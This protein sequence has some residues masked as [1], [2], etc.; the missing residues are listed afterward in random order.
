MDDYSPP[1]VTDSNGLISNIRS[2][3]E[4]KS[5]EELKTR[6]SVIRN[7]ALSVS[8][9]SKGY[10]NV[11]GSEDI[12]LNI[13]TLLKELDQ[14]C[15]SFTL[16]RGIYYA[17]RLIKSLDRRKTTSFSDINL[18][19][20]KDYDSILTDSF[21]NFRRRDNQGSHR[22]WY[23]G[24][25][26]PQ[27]PNQLLQRFTKRGE[28]VLDPFTGS[29]TTLIE[30]KRLGRNGIGIELNPEIAGKSELVVSTEEN[31]FNVR[32]KLL[33]GDSSTISRKE[34]FGDLPV[35]SAQFMILHPPY[36]DIIKFSNDSRD[37][38]NSLTTEDFLR[39]FANVVR[40]VKGFLDDN[41]YMALVIGDKYSHGEWIPL[42]FLAMSEILKLEFTLKS[43]IVKNFEDTR[44]KMN[45]SELWRYRALLGGYYVFK[46][47]Y[48]FIFKK[49][50]QR[51]HP[52]S[53]DG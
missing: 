1:D 24:N 40:N 7:I 50:R 30:C 43:I 16:D 31:P 3:Q 14:I 11:P 19:R 6:T 32:I 9:A 47:E 8:N 41:R 5:L 17:R 49:H 39:S 12:K 28:W 52:S 27:I 46:H 48:I 38:S 51:K 18:L 33:N 42:G 34:I 36:S 4:C 10:I 13:E 23:W 44:G 15:N 37:L 26:V 2:L 25:F 35:R 20:W 45:L 22:A 29:G 21:W 53:Q